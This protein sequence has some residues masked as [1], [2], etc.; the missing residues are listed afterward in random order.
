MRGKDLIG[1][2]G[3]NHNRSN[4]RGV[5][6]KARIAQTRFARKPV[7]GQP[8]NVQYAGVLHQNS[9]PW[10]PDDEERLHSRHRSSSIEGFREVVIC[11]EFQP[12]DTM[13]FT[14]AR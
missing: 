10:P 8:V 6:V 14:C 12:Q 11:P 1:M 7:D 4:S 5:K 2:P 3:K 13:D 9:G